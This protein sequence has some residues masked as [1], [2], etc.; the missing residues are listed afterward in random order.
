MS[1]TEEER[2]L[3]TPTRAKNILS[4]LIVATVG[5]V[6]LNLT[7]LLYFLVF[8][9]FDI[10]ARGSIDSPPAWIAPVRYTVFLVIIALISWLVF[11][12]KLP[13]LAKT[14]FLIV[15]AAVVLVVIG[16][17]SYPI[18]VLPYVI[19]AILTLGILSYFYRTHKHWLY[20][21]SIIL[22]ALVLMIFG[23]TGGEI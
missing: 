3:V 17:A 12:S 20:Y 4:A 11:R 13:V 6:L 8:Q 18:P 10:F 23:I 1:T 7:F 16:I 15:P 2:R 14:T 19:G 5:F 21:Y 9:F 22:T